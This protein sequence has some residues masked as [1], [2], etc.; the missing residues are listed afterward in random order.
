MSFIEVTGSDYM[1]LLLKRLNG[2][3]P[4]LTWLKQFRKIL[5]PYVHRGSSVLDV[6]CAVGYAY[7]SFKHQ[8]VAY[9]GLE[10]EEQYLKIA[11]T[12][13]KRQARAKF[14]QHDIVKN[15][16]PLRADIVICSAT[17]E[18]CSALMP[19]LKHIADAAT[20][21]LLLRTFLGEN[22]DIYT[23]PSPVAHYRNTHIKYINQYAFRDVLDFLEASGFK[24]RVYRDEY[25]DSI[26]QLV[27]GTVRTF[28]VIFAKRLKEN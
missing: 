26:P 12:Y 13:F 16:A 24:A 22:E 11:R 4:E 5:K 28:Y 3:V 2:K 23:I 10:F 21:V 1:E 27:D 9:T 15:V 19:V 20:G 14:I 7:K 17:I 8:G 18:H 25:T 6:G